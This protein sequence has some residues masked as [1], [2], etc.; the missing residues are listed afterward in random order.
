MT[1]IISQ[2]QEIRQNNLE[3][4]KRLILKYVYSEQIITRKELIA[5]IMINLKLV[6]RTAQEYMDSIL[7]TEF[8][9]FKDNKIVLKDEMP[10]L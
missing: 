4:I 9:V 10:K 8:L 1:N 5:Q 7:L 6:K 3:Y 2:R